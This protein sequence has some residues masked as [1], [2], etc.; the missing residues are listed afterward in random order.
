MG[1][2]LQH[3]DL[4]E[5]EPSLGKM[6]QQASH[7]GALVISSSLTFPNTLRCLSLP[8]GGALGSA[9]VFSSGCLGSEKL[10]SL[11]RFKGDPVSYQQ[12]L[13]PRQL[14]STESVNVPGRRAPY[15]IVCSA[16]EGERSNCSLTVRGAPHGVFVPLHMPTAL[17]FW[18]PDPAQKSTLSSNPRPSSSVGT[19]EDGSLP[20]Q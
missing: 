7:G 6:T 10:S 14:R 5:D 17:K 1:R 18:S 20:G 11:L 16:N 12:G 4:P 3:L 19:W 9:A 15:I 2:K 13:A 8:L